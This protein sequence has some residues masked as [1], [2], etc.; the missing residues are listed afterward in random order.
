MPFQIAKFVLLFGFVANNLYGGGSH[1]CPAGIGAAGGDKPK[2]VGNLNN[3]TILICGY[4]EKI[5]SQ[6]RRKVYSMSEFDVYKV[7]RNKGISKPIMTVGAVDNYK[8][9]VEKNRID[10]NSVERILKKT[11]P[12]DLSTLTC[13]RSLCS[14]QRKPI[15]IRVKLSNSEKRVFLDSFKSLV[16]LKHDKD[17]RRIIGSGPNKDLEILLSEAGLLALSGHKPAMDFF[18]D[19]PQYPGAAESVSNDMQSIIFT[20]KENRKLLHSKASTLIMTNSSLGTMPIKQGDIVTLSALKKAFP[21]FVFKVGQG[22]GD[23][24][25]FC[26]LEGFKGS[27]SVFEIRSK[28]KGR[29]K[30]NSSIKL[31]QII[32]KTSDIGTKLGIRVGDRISKLANKNPKLKL[33]FTHHGY[34]LGV[35]NVYYNLFAGFEHEP[36]KKGFANFRKK[37]PQIK[38]IS[39]PTENW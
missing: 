8:V 32:V 25:N 12:V 31:N 7:S 15:D 34:G 29:K 11:I 28:M 30:C 33:R 16:N 5:E 17:G 13:R 39:W 20:Q 36:S 4:L 14:F 19:P 38:S 37:N 22:S 10:F 26:Y 1:L 2:I 6:N 35:G 21:K 9:I 27:V 23:G 18:V 3:T 24:P